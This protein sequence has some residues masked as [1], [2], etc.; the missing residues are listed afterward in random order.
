MVARIVRD[1]EVAGSNPVIP[2]TLEIG[3]L[4]Q[5]WV[6]SF[7]IFDYNKEVNIMSSRLANLLVCRNLLDD[8]IILELAV[9]LGKKADPQTEY[10]LASRLIAEAERLG[11]SG[12][13]IRAYI[14]YRMIVDENLVARTMELS[15]GKIGRSLRQAFEHDIEILS[16]FFTAQPSEY[17]VTEILD[18][19]EP[20]KPPLIKRLEGAAVLYAEFSKKWTVSSLADAFLGYYRNYGSGD[21]AVY[22]AFRWDK[23]KGL[24]G[25]ENYDPIRFTDLIGYMDQKNELKRNTLAFLSDR[26]ANNVLLVGARGTGKS[27]SVK[28]LA[29]EYFTH[30][31]R[32]VQLTKPQ[33]VTLP[34]LLKTL[35]RFAAKKFIV[36]L[37]DLS[38]EDTEPE[39]KYL[40]SS[41]EGGVES[42]PPNVLI[43]ATSNRR[44][45]IKET[46][47]D[48]EQGDEVFRADSAN[49]TIS[50]SDRFGLVINYRAP[51]QNEYLAIIDHGLR[52]NGII[53]DPEELRLLG[54]RWEIEHSG[55]NGRTAKQFVDYYLGQNQ[56]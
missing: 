17:L 28:A 35:R 55:R 56:K 32:L 22:R 37:D 50:L 29:N 48:R 42:L 19:Y 8:P 41:I 26:P 27:S 2:T 15:N 45:L 3:L 47:R 6:S 12:N 51:N 24:V 1:D 11:F 25:I 44:H 10:R 33:L 5:Q 49:E 14:V 16:P 38:F 23:E 9:S 30:G 20:T 53:L 54:H 4:T 18:D 31:L 46:W 43:Y 7:F 40:K 21:I 39:D 52:Q 13:L 36:F 34:E